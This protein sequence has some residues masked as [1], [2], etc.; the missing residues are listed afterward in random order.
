MFD[1]CR[2][3][4]EVETSKFENNNTLVRI[5]DIIENKQV[6]FSNDHFSQQRYND[7]LNEALLLKSKIRK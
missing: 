2:N 3:S 4:E 1:C 6:K 7:T 5:S